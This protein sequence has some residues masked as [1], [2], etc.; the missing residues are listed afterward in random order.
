MTGTMRNVFAL[1]R[2]IGGKGVAVLT[3]I[4]VGADT[5]GMER[6]AS[7]VLGPAIVLPQAQQRVRD[8]TLETM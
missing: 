6:I 7:G 3:A 2:M 1:F 5:S 8:E 4:P